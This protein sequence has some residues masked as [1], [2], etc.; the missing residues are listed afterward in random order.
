VEIRQTAALPVRGPERRRDAAEKKD[1]IGVAVARRSR[2][3]CRRVTPLPRQRHGG[4]DCRGRTSHRRQ[5]VLWLGPSSLR[6]MRRTPGAWPH[7][8]ERG[9]HVPSDPSRRVQRCAGGDAPTGTFP[10]D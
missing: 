1:R 2:A 7:V 9:L 10:A 5:T 3:A 4:A 8:P 6:S